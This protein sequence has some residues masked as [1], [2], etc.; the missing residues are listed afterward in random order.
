MVLVGV[1]LKWDDGDLMETFT[2]C[3][4]RLR[5]NYYSRTVVTA[6]YEELDVYELRNVE[7]VEV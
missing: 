1:P 2:R 7:K 6:F 3:T 5:D 4:T